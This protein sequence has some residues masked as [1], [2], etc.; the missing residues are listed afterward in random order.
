M[1]PQSGLYGGSHVSLTELCGGKTKSLLS[2]GTVNDSESLPSSQTLS[3][4]LPTFGF[5]F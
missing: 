4:H 5:F 1:G 2:G 3:A